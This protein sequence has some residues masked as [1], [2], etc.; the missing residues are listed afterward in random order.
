MPLFGNTKKIIAEA[1]QQLDT[2][3]AVSLVIVS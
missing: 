1:L 2:K 3:I